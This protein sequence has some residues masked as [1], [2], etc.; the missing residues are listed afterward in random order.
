MSHRQGKVLYDAIKEAATPIQ[1]SL[2][3]KCPHCGEEIRIK[4][5][6]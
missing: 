2:I 4:I 3:V 5:E 6:K 1:S